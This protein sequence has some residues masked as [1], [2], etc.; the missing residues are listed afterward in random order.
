M[1]ILGTRESRSHLMKP[2]LL[3]RPPARGRRQTHSG[4]RVCDCCEQD[5]AGLVAVRCSV[6]HESKLGVIIL[7]NRIERLEERLRR[8]KLRSRGSLP[9]EV[10][11]SHT[12]VH[13]MHRVIKSTHVDAL[14]YK[15]LRE[16]VLCKGK[17]PRLPPCPRGIVV[18]P[19]RQS[20]PCTLNIQ[21]WLRCAVLRH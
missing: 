18:H 4:L 5:T 21:V 12:V 14:C 6:A 3:S 19:L 9:S 13:I 15:I 1:I 7:L 2:D 20:M 10:H 11:A 8:N 16:S 17:E